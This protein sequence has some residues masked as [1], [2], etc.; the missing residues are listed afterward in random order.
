MNRRRFLQAG[1]VGALALLLPRSGLAA[2]RAARRRER[3]LW[4]FNA[5]TEEEVHVVYWSRGSYVP[6]GLSRID[7]LLRDH[8]TGDVVSMDPCLLDLLHDLSRRLDARGPFHVIS[9]YRSP[10][11]NA[12][13]RAQ[14]HGVAKNSFHMKG[15]A[16][17]INL[18]GCPLPVLRRVALDADVG[19]VGYYPGPG[20]VHV[21]V[22]PVRRW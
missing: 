4:L 11:T 9:G 15:M 20:F 13:L 14:G 12:A 5:H 2:V 7:L 17:D 16:A 19:G 10:R 22:G 18:P 1:S 8:R 3:S 21:D 6:E